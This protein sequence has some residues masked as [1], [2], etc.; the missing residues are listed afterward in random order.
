[1]SRSQTIGNQTSSFRSQRPQSGP[2]AEESLPTTSKMGILVSGLP[3]TRKVKK[4]EKYMAND[5]APH[6]KLPKEYL[7]ILSFRYM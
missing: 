4:L 1:M 5:K 6:K 3:S 2:Q 7:G